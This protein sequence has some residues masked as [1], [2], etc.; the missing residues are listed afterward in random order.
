MNQ[1]RP[2]F[3][4]LLKLRLP[5]T[6]WTSIL[7]RVSGVLLFLSIPFLVYLLELSLSSAAGFERAA[8][9]VTHP[10]IQ[11]G[12]LLLSWAVIH[13]LL[14]G[15]RF[16]LIDIDIGIERESSRRSAWGVNLLALALLIIA[17]GCWL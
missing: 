9:L 4:N 12:A 2:V 16:L 6:S 5:V 3:L 15:I 14:A 1:T 8:E 11:A 13:H 17:V 7:H 10:L